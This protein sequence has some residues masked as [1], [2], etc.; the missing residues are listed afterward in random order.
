MFLLERLKIWCSGTNGLS[1]LFMGRTYSLKET[2]FVCY[3]FNMSSKVGSE[4]INQ[5]ANVVD[6]VRR[7]CLWELVEAFTG[8]R[9]SFI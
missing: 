3:T 6:R 4:G 2:F 7:R 8:L 5:R 9:D 1:K